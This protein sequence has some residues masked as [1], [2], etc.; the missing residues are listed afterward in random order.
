MDYRLLIV[1]DNPKFS[2]L[3]KDI[4][5]EELGYTVTAVNNAMEA[6]QELFRSKRENKRFDLIIT[7]MNLLGD[8]NLGDSK[9]LGGLLV[10][11][12]LRQIR[13]TESCVILSG[14]S[15]GMAEVRSIRDEYS[16][17]IFEIISK[18]ED[19]YG[20]IM[21]V[22]HPHVVK[23]SLRLF[24]SYRR[25][26]SIFTDLIYYKLLEKFNANRIFRDVESIDMGSDFREAI[27]DAITET[28]CMLVIIGPE[29]ISTTD[30]DGKP[31][32]HK[33]L[34]YV[35]FEVEDALRRDKPIIPVLLNDT[36]M[37]TADQL[38]VDMIPLA[39][40]NAI[41][42]RQGQD[43]AEDMKRLVASVEKY[44]RLD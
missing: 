9:D 16:D 34:D 25:L 6:Q 15:L 36:P 24:L 40:K 17:I 42:V 29:W 14:E 22:V 35:R 7:D 1:E 32:L 5:E 43:F 41:R 31:R 4:F 12:T 28:D 27:R 19:V 3:I 20:T 13:E 21:G 2:D 18:G 38:P 44:A 37:P 8:E 33:S 10:L 30:E 39:S 26:D 23:Y 11:K